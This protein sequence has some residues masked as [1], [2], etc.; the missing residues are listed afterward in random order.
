MSATQNIIKKGGAHVVPHVSLPLLSIPPLSHSQER[1]A[2][3]GAEGATERSGVVAGGGR[4]DGGRLAMGGGRKRS[5]SGA[6][7]VRCGAM[8]GGRKRSDD[9]RRCDGAKQRGG[10]R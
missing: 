8:A 9:G 4:S 5:G 7:T 6:A 10:Q 1:M 2:S 3:G